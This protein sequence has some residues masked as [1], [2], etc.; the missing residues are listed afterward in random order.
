V[1]ELANLYLASIKAAPMP[2]IPKCAPEMKVGTISYVSMMHFTDKENFA[3]YIVREG[4]HAFIIANEHG[5]VCA[6]S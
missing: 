6:K 4:A 5:L 3:D 1:W 2:E